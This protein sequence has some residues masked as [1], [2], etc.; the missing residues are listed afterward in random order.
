MIGKLHDLNVRMGVIDD[1][2]VTDAQPEDY[3]YG[4]ENGYFM[5]S[6]TGDQKNVIWAL[7]RFLRLDGL[8]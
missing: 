8:L 7:G 4:V 1:P 5:H 6:R 2:N 3:P